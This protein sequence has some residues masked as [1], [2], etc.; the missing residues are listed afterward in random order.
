MI[1]SSL[2]HKMLIPTYLFP[3]LLLSLCITAASPLY[4]KFPHRPLSFSPPSQHPI[5][6][7]RPTLNDDLTFHG[8]INVS[9]YGLNQPTLATYTVSSQICVPLV[10]E[11]LYIIDDLSRRLLSQ[12]L[13]GIAFPILYETQ[14]SPSPVHL[15]A[16]ITEQLYRLKFILGL[17]LKLIL[18]DTNPEEQVIS[19][20][21][22]ILAFLEQSAVELDRAARRRNGAGLG[23][24]SLLEAEVAGVSVLAEWRFWRVVD[25]IAIMCEG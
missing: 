8:T 23:S 19:P 22:S 18:L 6:N 12:Y 24:V 9:S 25:G 2:R 16:N 17:S 7:H 5:Q 1:V 14:S 11:V 20:W 3:C 4:S 21:Q 13:D 10:P 15:A